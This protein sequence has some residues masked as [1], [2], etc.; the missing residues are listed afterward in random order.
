MVSAAVVATC[1]DG[2]FSSLHVSSGG[3]SAVSIGKVGTCGA[4]MCAIETEPVCPAIEHLDTVVSEDMQLCITWDAWHWCRGLHWAHGAGS[5]GTMHGQ[6]I[7]D[8]DLG[9]VHGHHEFAEVLF[10]FI[11]EML[12]K[13]NQGLVSCWLDVPGVMWW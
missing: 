11:G 9:N 2:V 1:L 10:V 3:R 5:I 7:T 8:G 6:P 4:G 13:L 12:A